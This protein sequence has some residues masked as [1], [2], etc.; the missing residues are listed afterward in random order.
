MLANIPRQNQFVF[1]FNDRYLAGFRK[2]FRSVP[3]YRQDLAMTNV[4]LG[5]MLAIMG[6]YDDAGAALDKALPLRKALADE[7]PDNKTYALE[8]GSCYS[9][10]ANVVQFRGDPAGSLAWFAKG[11]AR[12]DP[13]LKEDGP[14]LRKRSAVMLLDREVVA[15][16]E[17]A[18]APPQAPIAPGAGL[19]A[20]RQALG[21]I[22]ARSV[23]P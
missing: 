2:D 10:I 11:L 19:D 5:E 13:V 23:G 14:Q 21:I 20:E 22:S 6:R 16:A 8:L 18:K 3:R 12:I 17:L 7:F 4:N 1:C 15:R 9:V